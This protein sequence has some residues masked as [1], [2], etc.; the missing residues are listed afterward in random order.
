MAYRE[1]RMAELLLSIIENHPRSKI[2]VIFGSAHNFKNALMRIP[3]D[4]G[5]YSLQ[6]FSWEG[7]NWYDRFGSVPFANSSRDL[8]VNY[9]KRYP[10]IVP[11]QLPF[12]TAEDVLKL[13]ID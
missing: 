6:R 8:Q 11:E 1:Q 3:A 4:K 2:A 5:R 9:L 10:T 7:R 12:F 13:A